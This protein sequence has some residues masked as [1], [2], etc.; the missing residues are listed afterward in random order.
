[1]KSWFNYSSANIVLLK[2]WGSGSVEID[3]RGSAK[4]SYK[5]DPRDKRNMIAGMKELARILVAAKA[6]GLS[7]LHSEGLNVFA[8]AGEP[9]GQKGLDRSMSR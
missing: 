8:E 1:M 4:V 6:T 2:E 3:K 7:S 5:L 9:L